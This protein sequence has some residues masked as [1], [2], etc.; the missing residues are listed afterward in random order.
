MTPART[1]EPEQ[2]VGHAA[3]RRRG[4]E[5][6]E[7]DVLAGG[8][9]VEGQVVRAIEAHDRELGL[10][11]LRGGPPDEA[12]HR[13]ARVL[14][15]VRPGV[16]GK[17]RNRAATEPER[18]DAARPL[19]GRGNRHAGIARDAVGT[20]ERAEVVVEGVVLLHQHDEVLDRRGG[21]RSAA[22]GS[23]PMSA[24][25]RTRSSDGPAPHGRTSYTTIA[26]RSARRPEAVEAGSA[27]TCTARPL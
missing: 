20:G 5:A 14:D 17:V 25:A 27:S 7:Q 9:P 19:A 2:V 23:A 11:P 3:A 1:G 12:I 10:L 4:E 13:A 18:P 16:V 15:P 24:A 22:A 8:A 21:W 26:G 6:V